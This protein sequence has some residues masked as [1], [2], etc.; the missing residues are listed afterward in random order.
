MRRRGRRL[1]SRRRTVAWIDGLSGLTT[2]TP[3]QVRTLPFTAL[4]GAANTFAAAVALTADADLSLHGG[5]DAVMTRMR[6]R[7][8]L[9]GGRLNPATPGA[10]SFFARVLITQRDVTPGA[11]V[12]PL[13][14]TTSAGLGRDD[15]LW[16]RD[17]LISGTTV[18]GAGTAAATETSTLNDYWFDV[19]V[20]ARRKV[21]AGYHIFLDV[22]TVAL[23]GGGAN[24]P[25]DCLLAGG[26]RMLMM[27]PR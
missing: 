27:R 11:N 6:G 25:V 26:L 14:F 17:V 18:V 12:A 23:G 2:A 3:V 20:K 24:Q 5:E 16:S 8:L 4:A 13:D 19:D 22:Q 9:Y 1:G 15:I 10:A 7:L 21:Q